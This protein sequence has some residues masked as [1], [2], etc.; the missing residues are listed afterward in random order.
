[1]KYNYKKDIAYVELD[2]LAELEV[3]VA[4]WDYPEIPNCFKTDEIIQKYVPIID[5]EFQFVCMVK[6]EDALVMTKIINNAD[7]NLYHPETDE[8]EKMM[9][10]N[11]CKYSNGVK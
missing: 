10:N 1:M 3:S 6:K 5:A 2:N 9:G 7:K 8:E 4:T 11:L